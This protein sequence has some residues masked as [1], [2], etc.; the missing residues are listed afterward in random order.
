MTTRDRAI[1]T[2][3][4]DTGVDYTHPDLAG[5][6]WSAPASFTVNVGGKSITC[7][8]G[9]HGFNA[10]LKTCNPM[11]DNGHGTHVSGTIGATGNNAV[12]VTGVNWTTQIMGAKFLDASGSG[13]TADAINAIEFAVQAKAAF[14]A[15]GT[16]VNVRVLSNSWGGGDFSQALLDE[17]NKANDNDMLFVAAAGN[18]FSNNDTK[19][20]Y[21][22]SFQAPNMLVVAA[23][24]NPDSLAWFSNYGPTT[25]H[26]AA[27]GVNILSTWPGATYQLESGTSMATPHVSGAALLVL[28]KCPMDTAS[29]KQTLIASVDVIPGLAGTTITG[30]RVNINRAIRAC[31]SSPSVYSVSAAQSTVAPSG[32]MTVSWTAPTGQAAN[33]WV[34]LFQSGAPNTAYLWYQFTNGTT[35]GQVTLT[36]PAQT[37]QYEFRYLIENGYASQAQSNAVTVSTSVAPPVVSSVQATNI[38]SSGATITWSTS[39]SADSQVE[40]GTT[41]SYG[42]TTTLDSNK[43]TAHTVTLANL[44]ASTTYHYRV[45][46]TDAFGILTV[47]GDFSFSTPIS[48]AGFSLSASPGTVNLG[49][50]VTV[51]WTAPSGRP[52]NDW[53]GLFAVGAPNTTYLW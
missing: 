9:T 47:S 26:L 52:G 45:R 15:T 6:V 48:S 22:A 12:G 4:V 53:V 46:S 36:G 2:G 31:T 1:V 41:T 24:D 51:T 44:T 11:D 3:V 28:S 17:I 35:S 33:D 25:V 29:L 10:I 13:S 8:A 34:G 19:A 37:G 30:G 23:N 20:T 7:A 18:S 42:S 38:S 21:P 16:P 40:Y 14:A 49:G 5:N 43:V 50:S 32:A 39:T 27:P